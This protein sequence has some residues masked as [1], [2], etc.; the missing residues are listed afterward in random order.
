MKTSN[1]LSTFLSI[2]ISICDKLVEIHTYKKMRIWAYRFLISVVLLAIDWARFVRGWLV[3][4]LFEWLK[5]PLPIMHLERWSIVAFQWMVWIRLFL[6]PRQVSVIVLCSVHNRNLFIPLEFRGLISLNVYWS[7]RN[8]WEIKAMIP[9]TMYNFTNLRVYYPILSKAKVMKTSATR[10]CPR[11]PGNGF[12]PASGFWWCSNYLCCGLQ[13]R[14]TYN[15]LAN[16]SAICRL[17]YLSPRYRTSRAN[18]LR[19]WY[20][21]ANLGLSAAL[22]IPIFPLFYTI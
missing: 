4:Y 10:L 17:P 2:H 19:Q 7:F 21:D 14:T 15:R 6:T 9:W 8:N 12:S 5:R 18:E 13:L 16:Y 20:H 22:I 11:E 1:Y 3:N